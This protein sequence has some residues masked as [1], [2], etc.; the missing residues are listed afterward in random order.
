M[1]LTPIKIFLIALFAPCIFIALFMFLIAPLFR[2]VLDRGRPI[3]N[4]AKEESRLFREAIKDKSRNLVQSS[5]PYGPS[6]EKI[7][8]FREETNTLLKSHRLFQ[9]EQL[10]KLFKISS[11]D[12]GLT[13]IIAAMRVSDRTAATLFYLGSLLLMPVLSLLINAANVVFGFPWQEPVVLI[14]LLVTPILGIFFAFMGYRF[15]KKKLAAVFCIVSNCIY[16]F[17]IFNVVISTLE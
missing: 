8:Q 12:T 16:F 15:Y 7:D 9:R 10:K 2:K 5:Y 17:L 6:K 3:E 4:Q 1:E 13:N 11:E 14:M